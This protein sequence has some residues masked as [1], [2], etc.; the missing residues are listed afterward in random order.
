MILVFIIVMDF[1]SGRFRPDVFFV[2]AALPPARPIF[3]RQERRAKTAVNE[4]SVQ[5]AIASGPDGA[6]AVFTGQT[7]GAARPDAYA[8]G[9]VF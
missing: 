5:L 8:Y 7:I 6:I 2:N 9:L 4:I 1:R 3:P